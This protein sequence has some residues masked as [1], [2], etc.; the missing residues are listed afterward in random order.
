MSL[1]IQDHRADSIT[2]CVVQI[3]VC[4]CK[5]LNM[6]QGIVTKLTVKSFR[7]GP[8]WVSQQEGWLRRNYR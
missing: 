5:C 2:L 6:G 3:Y 8:V 1:T 4:L 7:Q